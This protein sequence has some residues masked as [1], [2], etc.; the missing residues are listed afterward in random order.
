MELQEEVGFFDPRTTHLI[1]NVEDLAVVLEGDPE[2]AEDEEEEL[3]KSADNR[4][5]A[6]HKLQA[7]LIY[8]CYIVDIPYPIKGGSSDH[9]NNGSGAAA[10]RGGA[11]LPNRA[12]ARSMRKLHKG[13]GT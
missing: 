4:L 3:G 6:T 2:E 5:L 11:V 12:R 7:T 8:K 9:Y 1:T 13:K 10:K